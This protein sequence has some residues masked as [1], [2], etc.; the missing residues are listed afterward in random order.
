[1][2]DPN[3]SIS[4]GGWT[5]GVAVETWHPGGE[6]PRDFHG[7]QDHE[8]EDRNLADERHPRVRLAFTDG[9][10]AHTDGEEDEAQEHEQEEPQG[11]Q[12]VVVQDDRH[13]DDRQV[14]A[15]RVEVPSDERDLVTSS[16]SGLDGARSICFSPWGVRLKTDSISGAFRPR[17]GR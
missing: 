8:C 9:Q 15:R 17:P 10:E 14:V 5:L 4:T 1:M 12:A 3:G 11:Q 13:C 6:P 7:I 2:T 16:G